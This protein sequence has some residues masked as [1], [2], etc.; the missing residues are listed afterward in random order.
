MRA[1]LFALAL[2]L[3]CAACTSSPAQPSDPPC[4]TGL[5][6]DCKAS[7][8]PPIYQTIFDKILHPTCATGS[9]TCHTADGAK[10]GLVF[11]NADDAY[12]LLLGKNPGDHPR[13]IAGDPACSLI[14]KRLTSSDPSYHMPPGDISLS[15]ADQ[16]TIVQWIADGAKR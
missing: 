5:S 6:A 13:V 8:D 10:N 3:G 12:A 14:M 7:Y 9:G 11:E 2:L 4:V 1:A 16:C 15:A